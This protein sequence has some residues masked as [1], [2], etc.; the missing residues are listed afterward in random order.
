MKS[1]RFVPWTLHDNVGLMIKDYTWWH[2]HERE[3]L[4][5]MTEHL[6][7]GI[8]HQEGIVIR[9]DT[10]KDRMMFLLRWA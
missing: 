4:N 5:W 6:P 8:D 3:I 2:D 7:D 1:S 9:F 10:D